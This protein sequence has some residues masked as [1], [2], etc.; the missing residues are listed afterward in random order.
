MRP[1]TKPRVNSDEDRA[2]TD[3]RTPYKSPNRPRETTLKLV[4]V[5][6][7]TLMT[8]SIQLQPV[9]AFNMVEEGIRGSPASS[10]EITF[11]RRATSHPSRIIPKATLNHVKTHHKTSSNSTQPTNRNQNTTQKANRTE[12][13]T[14]QKIFHTPILPRAK[15]KQNMPHPHII[16]K[17]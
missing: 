4:D 12:P 1:L 15:P 6:G 2:Q 14:T 16:L 17:Y 11:S 9:G 13:H 3:P 10:S 5:T 8:T 7:N